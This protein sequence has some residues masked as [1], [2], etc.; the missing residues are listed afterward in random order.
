MKIHTALYFG[1]HPPKNKP[2]KKYQKKMMVSFSKVNSV[3]IWPFLGI[4]LLDF[5]GVHLC[6]TEFCRLLFIK[7]GASFVGNTPGIA[8]EPLSI[9]ALA[10]NHASS[11]GASG[12]FPGGKTRA[13]LKSW[14]FP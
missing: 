2:P 4:F 1:L 6:F 8:S 5:W 9:Q 3:K 13:E 10:S 7:T 12:D 11:L 14:D